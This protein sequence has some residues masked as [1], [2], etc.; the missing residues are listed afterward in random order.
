MSDLAARNYKNRAINMRKA[1]VIGIV[2]MLIGVVVTPVVNSNIVNKVN[3]KYS[4]EEDETEYYAVIAACSR[5]LKPWDNLPVREEVLKNLYRAL[6][7]AP[8]WDE[9]NIILLINNES[10]KENITKALEEMAGRVTSNDVFLFSWQGHGN[11]VPDLDGDEDDGYDEIICPYDCYNDF[12]R[13]LV[14]YITDDELNEY[15]SNISAKGMLLTF[16]SCLSGGLIDSDNYLSIDKN[17]DRFIILS[18]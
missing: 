2:A 9:D 7:N 4:I 12:P 16:D 3:N 15:L 14:N 17:K 6:I 13:G 18:P 11:E 1:L 5:Y 10:T 8:N